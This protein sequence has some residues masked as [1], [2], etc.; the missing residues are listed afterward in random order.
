MQQNYM[1]L[2]Q[3]RNFGAIVEDYF[4]FFK[5]NVKPF[6]SLFISYNGI[7]ILLLLGISYLLV[8]GFIGLI[9]H[10]GGFDGTGGG[11]T[12]SFI[13]LG[14]GFLFLIFVF[15]A[16]AALNY[17]LAS[18]YM[19]SYE[20]ANGTMVENKKVWSFISSR[21]G[22]IIVFILL[23][24]L[25][26]GIYGVASII[27]AF[28][29]IIGAIIQYIFGFALSAWL[30]I[31][32]MVLLAEGVAPID[33][34]SKGMELLTANFKKCIGVNFILGILV[35]IL[36]IMVLMIPGFIVGIYQYHAL[37]SETNLAESAFSKIIYTLGLCAF[38][39]VAAYA[40]SLSQFINGILYFT[41]HEE[42]YNVKT[43]ERI[44]QIGLE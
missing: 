13:Y 26:Y 44:S 32:F 2:R 31:S 12:E 38:L 43:R 14:V 9:D 33:A 11:S 37:Y 7:F 42:K 3:R 21:L 8:T 30:G 16:V 6:T 29:P 4:T 15:I 24:F 34:Y 40:Q 27:L 28:I 35:G 39:V 10:T 22:H 20:K 25:I 17:S 18:A 23:L 1:E 5:Q 41:L 19:I 36:I